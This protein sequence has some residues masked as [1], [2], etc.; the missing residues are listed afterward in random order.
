MSGPDRR[1]VLTWTM[2]AAVAPVIATRA[3]A[4][5][6]SRAHFAPAAGPM[7]FTRRL[8]RQLAGGAALVVTRRFAVG[9]TAMPEGWAVAGEQTDV[10]VDAPPRI[11]QLASLERQR[12]ETG[13]FPLTL[14]SEGMIAGGPDPQV[15]KQLDAALAIV[16]R[17]LER[18]SLAGGERAQLEAFARAVHD[19]SARMI[20]LLPADLF[21]PRQATAHA[22]RR[23]A[24]PG[25]GAGTIAV[26]FSAVSDPATGVMRSAAREI[27]TAIG[28][29]RRLTRE[30][31]TLAP[32]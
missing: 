19:S 20:A 12:V 15:G 4:A 13:L 10:A 32:A 11:A 21:A 2:A 8:E 18:G 30:D 24:L 26:T 31:W 16:T 7:I 25:G 3:R 17:G 9:F 22:E 14:D 29:D 23:L 6:E 28:D 27:V 1:T 5:A